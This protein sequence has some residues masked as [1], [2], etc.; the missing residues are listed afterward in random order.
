MKL[1]T[2]TCDL[3]QVERETWEITEGRQYGQVH[4]QEMAWLGPVL[5]RWKSE[6]SYN[7]TFITKRDLNLRGP[8]K[9]SATRVD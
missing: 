6:N 5:P 1:G 8:R 4:V 7:E 2:S 3:Y 9:C